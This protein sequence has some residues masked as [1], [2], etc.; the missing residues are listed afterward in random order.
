M[1]E[2]ARK[3]ENAA[4]IAAKTA[5]GGLLLALRSG[6]VQ[7][8]QVASTLLVAHFVAPA[9]YGVL[10]VALA[11]IGFA[12]YVGDLGVSNSFLSLP[13]IDDATFRT[14]AFAALA[15]AGTEALILVGLAPLLASLLHGPGDSALVIRVLATCL[16][17]EALRFGPTVTLNRE[18]RF[19]V[20][21][22]VTLSES[23]ILY[24]SQIGL[25][26][27]GFGLWALVLA[28]LARSTLGTTIYLWKGGGLRRPALRVSVVPLMRRA[29]PY[30]GPAILAAAAGLL[31]PI[32]LT[33]ILGT[34][35]VGYWGW[36]TVL[37]TPIMT[38]VLIVSGIT[39]PSLARL[40]R[41][42]PASV[43]RASKLMVR[44][45]I[46]IPAAGAGL[47]F[48][49]AHPLIDVLFGNRWGPATSAARLNLIGI[50][51]LTLGY[52]LAAVLESEQRARER[53]VAVLVATVAGLVMVAGLGTD[54]GLAGATFTT[55]VAAPA[56]DVAIL[57]WMAKLDYRRAA[58]NSFVLFGSSGA[59]AWCLAGMVDN[60]GTLLACI[61]LG[62][63]V[64]GVFVWYA[65]REAV[66][67]VLRFGVRLPPRVSS[68]LGVTPPPGSA[69]TAVE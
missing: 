36:S 45:S 54:F 34:Q 53:L 4:V 24:L 65:D 2:V 57:G 30:Q 43:E 28:Q 68:V 29:L 9:A 10:T 52:F 26:I 15:L 25:L 56:I 20:Y 12:R 38:I 55:A 31:F 61:M 33:V 64:S 35:G 7:I 27:A 60:V 18:L 58:L 51:P 49:F 47:L 14:G 67:T 11:A 13:V 63:L 16:L 3:T 41:A 40:R 44:A 22:F 19:G 48:G 21:G 5:R 17:F 39:L 1:T 66:R 42:E 37:A 59:V 6:V 8:M 62:A 46:V 23:L 69:T 32:V 50:V